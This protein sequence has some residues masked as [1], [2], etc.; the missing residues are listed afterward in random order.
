V[1][2]LVLLFAAIFVIVSA[3]FAVR[4]II[5]PGA[6]EIPESDRVIMAV[7]KAARDLG[8]EF[9]AM[10]KIHSP[11]TYSDK[12]GNKVIFQQFNC[13]DPERIKSGDVSFYTE[14]FDPKEA[15]NAQDT[16][17]NGEKALLCEKEGRA[18]L[19]WYPNE[20]TIAMLNYAPNIV[21]GEEI[22]KMAESC[23][24]PKTQ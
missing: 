13:S 16:S 8:Y 4:I 15:E 24:Y 23:Q 18:Y 17:V 9:S 6:S 2:K 22:M 7:S 14:V 10:E 12:D 21:S 19:I 11:V 3:V 20:T 1:K 5:K